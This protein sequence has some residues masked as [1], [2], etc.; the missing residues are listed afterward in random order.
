MHEL[1]ATQQTN[2]IEMNLRNVI[3]LPLLLLLISSSILVQGQCDLGPVLSFRN[4]Y[5]ESGI[6]GRVGA[7]YRFTQVLDTV[8]A[9]VTIANKINA[10]LVDIDI[11]YL[12]DDDSFQ[13]QVKINQQSP[14]GT[15]GYIDFE[16]KFVDSGTSD[17]TNLRSWSVTAVD[18]DGDGWKLRESVGFS[19]QES[20]VLNTPS[21]LVNSNDDS[22]MAVMFECKTVDN[23]ED[24]STTAPEHMVLLTF[25]AESSFMYRT[26][27]IDNGGAGYSDADARL[28]SLNMS[29][30]LIEEFENPEIFPIELV[31]FEG[32]IHEGNVYLEWVTASELNNDHFLIQ[33]STDGHLFQDVGTVL[34]VGNSQEKVRYVFQDGTPVNDRLFYRLKQID[35][36]GSYSL[37]NVIEVSSIPSTVGPISVQVFPNPASTSLNIKNQ[38]LTPLQSIRMF[39]IYGKE[40]ILDIN[41]TSQDEYN[42]NLSQLMSGNYF[43]R[44]SS[45]SEQQSHRVIIQ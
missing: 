18:V 26:K 21:D 1:I 37:S 34:G 30:C 20:H 32:L 27:V 10:R 44:V 16:I 13:P 33:R 23:Q 25:N 7:V 9:L 24:I 35:I 43:L 22:D 8:D 45:A 6:D 15:E 39:D 36:D 17:L 11:S 31:S 40:V 42:V 29:P 5:L 12:G 14:N 2:V 28:F 41:H 19:N 4:H 38:S 3:L